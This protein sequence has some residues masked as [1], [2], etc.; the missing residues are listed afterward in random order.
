[1]GTLYTGKERNGSHE[2]KTLS[3]SEAYDANHGLHEKKE[4][5]QAMKDLKKKD[6]FK[7]AG[8]HLQEKILGAMKKEAKRR[9]KMKFMG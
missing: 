8:K 9:R 3:R 4:L 7:N 5:L 1:M 2:K 6:Y